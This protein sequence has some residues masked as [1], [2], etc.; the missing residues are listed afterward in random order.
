MVVDILVLSHALSVRVPVEEF[1]ITN[2]PFEKP[3]VVERFVIP[4]PTAKSFMFTDQSFPVIHI[5]P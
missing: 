5:M 2:H 3:F 1:T 4:F